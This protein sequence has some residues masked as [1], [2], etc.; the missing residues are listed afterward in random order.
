MLGDNINNDYKNIYKLLKTS[1]EIL[2]HTFVDIFCVDL[3]VEILSPSVV[4]AIRLSFLFSL[5]NVTFIGR[6]PKTSMNWLLAQSLCSL[7]KYNKI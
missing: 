6:G 5:T 3:R 1:V 4:L 2:D 7:L